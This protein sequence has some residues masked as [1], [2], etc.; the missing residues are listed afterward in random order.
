MKKIRKIKNEIGVV[1]RFIISFGFFRW[2][3]LYFK[4]KFKAFQQFHPPGIQFPF[5]LRKNS[6]DRSIFYELFVDR[7]MGYLREIGQPKY[8]IDGG[9][10]IGLSAIIYKNLFPDAT[11]IC[12]EPDSANV[13]MLKKNISPYTNI[14]IEQA[15]IWNNDV[16]LKVYDKYGFGQSGLVVEEDETNGNI[17]GLT[18]TS[19]MKKYN[20]PRVDLLKLDIETSEKYLFEKNYQDW[21]PMVK[22]ILIELHDRILPGCGSAFFHAVDSTYHQ[23]HFDQFDYYTLVI[24]LNAPPKS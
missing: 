24:N 20:L 7:N 22:S 11:I 15:G 3:P 2:I 16:K 1:S 8:I 23:Y 21:L 13:E 18:I 10:N 14:Y 17:Q 19:I 6:T 5:S 12:I 9:A 4:F